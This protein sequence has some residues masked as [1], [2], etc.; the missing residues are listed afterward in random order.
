M[1]F[2]IIAVIITVAVILLVIFGMLM[3]FG[4]TDMKDADPSTRATL[5]RGATT[6]IKG[7]LA[8]IAMCVAFGGA[9]VI[10]GHGLTTLHAWV[11]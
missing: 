2:D 8:I 6:L 3:I 9:G 5:K 7:L 11:F 10:L 1:I 4:A